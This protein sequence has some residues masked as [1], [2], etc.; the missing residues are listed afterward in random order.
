M[1]LSSIPEPWSEN[2]IRQ[3]IMASFTDAKNTINQTNGGV[4]WQQLNDLQDTV[5]IA[6]SCVQDLLDE[7]AIFDIHSQ[8]NDFW[9]SVNRNHPENNKNIKKHIYC[10]T[11]AFMSIVDHAR[12]FN[13]KY[14]I[15]NYQ[16]KILE[17]FSTSGE[18]EFIKKLRNYNSHCKISDANW[19]IK[20]TREGRS[21]SFN[22][23]KSELEKWS[24]WCSK[25]KQFIS[26]Q[27]EKID[28]SSIFISYR[29][30]VLKFYNWH[31]FMVID[32]YS[33]ELNQ[34]FIYKKWYDKVH[35]EL[36]W[37]MILSHFNKSNDAYEYLSKYITNHQLEIILSYEYKSTEQIEKLIEIID[38]NGA[39]TPSLKSKIFSLVQ[40]I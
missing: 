38:T 1:K 19:L 18:H 3:S 27:D 14:P 13:D 34:F 12:T 31:K 11:S 36:S 20:T 5:W 2:I 8:R 39:C 15:S 16:N 33:K 23:S 29:D 6:D 32:I 26:V 9:H 37:N 17:V 28:I 21:V 7:I 30:K 22:L 10:A 4:I 25:S 35:I 24:G 40:K